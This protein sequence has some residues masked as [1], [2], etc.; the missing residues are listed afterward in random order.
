MGRRFSLFLVSS[1]LSGLFLGSSFAQEL[2]FDGYLEGN[3]SG[4]LS[5]DRPAGLEGGD[6]ILGEERLQL[7]ISAKKGPVEFFGRGYIFYDNLNHEFDTD[8]RE[9]YL[10]YS[11]KRFELRAGRQVVTWGVG[12]LLFIN[13]IFPKDRVS[14]F[15]GRPLE[16]LKKGFDGL[17]V[18]IYPGFLAAELVVIPFFT[19]DDF[20]TARRFSLFDPLAQFP[21]KTEEPAATWEN[22]ELG[23]RLYRTI[24][25][26]D[27]S[28][29]AYRGFFRTPGTRL[30]PTGATLFFP[31]LAV[32]GFT[33]QGSLLGGVVGLE[34]AYYD[35]R[36]DRAGKDPGIENSHPRVLLE[37]NREFWTDFTLG[38][39]YYLEGMLRLDNYKRTL[40]PGF[41]ARERL[42]QYVTI[43]L[44]QLLKYQTVKLSLFAIYG[45]DDRDYWAN[46]EASYQI[47]DNLRV[48]V[49]G[50]IFGGTKEFTPFGQLG[51]NDN[52]Y[53]T[54]R[55]NFSFHLPREKK[56]GS[57]KDK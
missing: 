22:T 23:L 25:K 18:G 43:R 12:D 38:F 28:I 45:I 37:F 8:F 17:K 6:F 3:Y 44:T 52:L 30:T 2:T 46:P 27:V 1:M 7:K 11:S 29:H 42:R 47:T 14:L 33:F 31:R 16:Y 15:S 4:R 51:K 54:A 50:N 32:Y 5:R 55:Y 13:D 49:G 39:Q 48:V 26:Y 20:P 56:N 41:P 19:P 36:D 9:G 34:G 24:G 21:K 10:G 40:P 35:S 57:G 53:V